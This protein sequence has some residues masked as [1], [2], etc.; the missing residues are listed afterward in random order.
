MNRVS[1]LPNP[2]STFLYLP[3]LSIDVLVP[4]EKP[5]E[6]SAFG[7]AQREHHH[8]W[9]GVAAEEHGGAASVLQHHRLEGLL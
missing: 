7:V 5:W 6:K 1:C 9:E 2:S 3:R 4:S 8:S